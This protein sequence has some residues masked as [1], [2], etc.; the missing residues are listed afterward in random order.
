MQLIP[1]VITRAFARASVKNILCAIAQEYRI[2]DLESFGQYIILV[3]NFADRYGMLSLINKL[4][5]TI[6]NLKSSRSQLLNDM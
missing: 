4:L 6:E 2:H 1:G 3:V 5:T